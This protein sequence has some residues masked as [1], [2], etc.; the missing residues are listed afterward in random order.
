VAKRVYSRWSEE[1]AADRVGAIGIS[2]GGG[3]LEAAARR[4]A[5]TVE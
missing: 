1:A 4:R 5:E 3:L 2:V